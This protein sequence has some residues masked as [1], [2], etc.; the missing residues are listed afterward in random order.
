MR[1]CHLTGL[2]NS[3]APLAKP[4]YG[5]PVTGVARDFPIGAI[6][7]L[8]AELCELPCQRETHPAPLIHVLVDSVCFQNCAFWLRGAAGLVHSRPYAQLASSAR[9]YRLLSSILVSRAGQVI[10]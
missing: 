3:L 10:S 9:S 7:G 8:V 1:G 6:H 2:L 5:R 4:A